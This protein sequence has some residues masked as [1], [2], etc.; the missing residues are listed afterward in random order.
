M[1]ETTDLARLQVIEQALYA[2][3][4]DASSALNKTTNDTARIALDRLITRLE[5]ATLNLAD[6]TYFLEKGETAH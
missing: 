4:D 1:I 2:I 3:L 6:A 5:T